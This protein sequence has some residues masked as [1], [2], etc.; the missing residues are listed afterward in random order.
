MKEVEEEKKNWRRKSENQK[1]IILS[2]QDKEVE[3]LKRRI[4]KLKEEN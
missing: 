4:A 1:K 2:K 3:E